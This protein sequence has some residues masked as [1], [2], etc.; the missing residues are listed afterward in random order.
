MSPAARP[1]DAV[2][3]HRDVIEFFA[4]GTLRPG[5]SN[6]PRIEQWVD[7][8]EPAAVR[9]RMFA[10]TAGAWP[11]LE[12]REHGSEWVHGDLLTTHPSPE[13]WELLG[14]LELEWGY[15]LIW[16]P[17]H[18]TPEGPSIGQAM[19]CAWPWPKDR[20]EPIPGGDWL[21]FLDGHTS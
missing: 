18:A 20:G 13:L 10:S 11:L 15:D 7:A 2:H 19:L 21:A 14:T 16:H 17:I 9:G 3:G 4:Y 8:V 12:V 5:G 1:A 6:F